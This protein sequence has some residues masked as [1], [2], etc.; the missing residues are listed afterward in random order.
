MTR[1]TAGLSPA[2]SCAWLMT[3]A[4]EGYRTG[5]VATA[6]QVARGAGKGLSSALGVRELAKRSRQNRNDVAKHLATLT[7]DGFLGPGERGRGWGVRTAYG[8]TLP[9]MFASEG[10]ELA[11]DR[12]P[13]LGELAP[14]RGPSLAAA[15]F[16][17]D[18]DVDV[19]VARASN[20]V[21]QVLEACLR[22]GLRVHPSEFGFVRKAI[23][24]RLLEMPADELAL[25][26]EVHFDPRRPDG[27]KNPWTA[28]FTCTRRG[29]SPKDRLATRKPP[30]TPS[31]D[32]WVPPAVQAAS[33]ETRGAKVAEARAALAA[34]RGAS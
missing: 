25:R 27:F 31:P 22:H 33:D 12:G 17:S 13:S 34:L 9:A 21:E 30:G 26:F 1:S 5:V 19:D 8:L 7:T 11:P 23:A 10:G 29:L 3:V 15:P 20:E 14:D 16:C 2:S 18:V 6:A 4:A 32:R 28:F 24:E